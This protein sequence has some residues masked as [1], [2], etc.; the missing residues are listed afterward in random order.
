MGKW[1]EM[2]KA[3]SLALALCLL[4]ARPAA[5]QEAAQAAY[6]P[7]MPTVA[8][9]QPLPQDSGQ[10]LR[11]A[12]CPAGS[13]WLCCEPQVPPQCRQCG[14]VPQVDLAIPPEYWP[15]PCGECKPCDPLQ[16][17]CPNKE[18]FFLVPPRPCF[19][20]VFDG[21]AIGRDLR[22]S[23]ELAELDVL[24]GGNTVPAVFATDGFDRDFVGAG[25]L[26]VGHTFGECFQIEGTYLGVREAETR[27]I[28]PN[29]D[30]FAQFTYGSSLQSAELYLRRKVPM[31][32]E[33]LSVSILFGV[34]YFALPEEL[35]YAPQSQG[36]GTVGSI[37]VSTDNA[38]IGPE[39]GALFQFSSDNR[40]WVNFEAKAAALNNH[41]VQ[42]TTFFDLDDAGVELAAHGDHTAFAGDLTLTFIYRWSTHFATRLGYQGIFLTGLALAPDNL[43][44][45]APLGNQGELQHDADAIYHG[46]FAGIE[47]GW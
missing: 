3:V 23:F 25:R 29:G 32:P 10:P 6:P 47:V 45:N 43:N 39:I 13:P 42:S 27:A 24:N 7:G 19:Y 40:W 1:Q 15:P 33:R 11:P 20:A 30:D 38:L 21:A 14:N 12:P 31:P 16:T 44:T 2:V 4:V 18:D 17:C 34:R 28:V 9:P 8:V 26:L 36:P 46:P 41:A 35:D 5:S 22:R 37:H